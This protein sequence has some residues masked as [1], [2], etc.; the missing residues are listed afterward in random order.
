MYKKDLKHF[1]IHPGTN[2]ILQST[3]LLNISFSYGTKYS[4]MDQVKLAGDSL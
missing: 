1:K 2:R 4:R 3:I